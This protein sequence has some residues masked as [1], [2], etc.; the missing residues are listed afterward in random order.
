V[1]VKDLQLASLQ[2][3]ISIVSQDISLFNDT[4]GS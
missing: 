4:I 3:Q 1:D 2:E